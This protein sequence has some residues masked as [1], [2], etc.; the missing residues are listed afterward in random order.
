MF[1]QTLIK[2][3]SVIASDHDIEPEALMAVIEVESNG[4]LGAKIN[5]RLEPMI[6][7][8]GHYFYRLLP[9]AKRNVAIV[10]GLASSRAGKIK[11]PFRQSARWKLL[12]RAEAIDRSA[13]L[14]SI[15]WG[16]GQVMGSHWRWLGFASVDA[17]VAKVREGATGQVDLMMR[18]IAKAGLVEKLQNH[19]WA[20]FAR[21]YNGP[22]YKRYKY[23]VKMRKAYQKFCKSSGRS[24]APVYW[25][26]RNRLSI[27]Q[28]G[29]L[30]DAVK[31]LQEKLKAI[32]FMLAIDGDFGPATERALKTFQRECRLKI[33]GIFGPKTL[34]ML[35]RKLP[36]ALV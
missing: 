14:S 35:R 13:A 18:Y 19:D 21:A 20:G 8:E 34:E 4:K 7:F 30:G 11:N 6:R 10:R 29:S 27:L 26:E 31:E 17:L 12:K 15:S 9:T 36:P 3:I 25:R 2:E 33:D 5:G 16:V 23:D 1:D 28:L 32:G 22:A 24:S